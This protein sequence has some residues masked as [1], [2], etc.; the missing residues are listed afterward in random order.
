MT[1]SAVD[2]SLPSFPLPRSCP[3]APPSLTTEHR[4]TEPIFKVKI[5]NGNDAWVVTRHSDGRALLTDKRLSADSLMP[6]MPHQSEGVAQFRVARNFIGMDVPEH[7]YYRRKIA[8]DFGPKRMELL[9][10][11]VQAIVD[12]RIQSLLEMGPPAELIQDFA[13]PVTSSVICE[14]LGVPYEHHEHFESLSSDLLSTFTDTKTALGIHEQLLAFLGELFDEKMH[15]PGTDVLSSLGAE[16]RAGG[17]TRREAV[18]TAYLLLVAG[19]E[20][21]AGQISLGVLAL[22]MHPEQKAA[23]A[24]DPS[25]ADNAVEEILRYVG[26]SQ[27][28]RRRVALCDFEFQGVKISKGDGIIVIGSSANRDPDVFEDADVFDIHRANASAHV[29]FG[30][31][32]HICL[33]R[34]LARLELQVVFSTLFQRIPNLT[35]A[36]DLDDL[37]FKY[38]ATVYGLEALPITW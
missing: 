18:N 36:V 6:G 21:T 25:L 5:W 37:A 33:G 35:A 1:N 3:F 20:T 12:T 30:S 2:Q 24:T 4:D 13:L 38:N 9:R 22:A 11:A 29:E 17:L 26:V 14:L 16:V 7:R 15:S 32:T 8:D 19:H 27:A 31:G 23:L 10:P 28:G 34:P